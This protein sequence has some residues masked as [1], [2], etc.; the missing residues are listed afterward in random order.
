MTR[1][2]STVDWVAVFPS[3]F[4][5]EDRAIDMG[6][7]RKLRPVKLGIVVICMSFCPIMCLN[8]AKTT[9]ACSVGSV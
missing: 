4:E 5:K 2:S 8:R 6:N 3:I 1:P 7:A 9:F